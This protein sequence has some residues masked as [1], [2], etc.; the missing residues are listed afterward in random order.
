MLQR[1]RGKVTVSPFPLS[2]VCSFILSDV[3]TVEVV[4]YSTLVGIVTR[5]PHFLTLFG[6]RK[7]T[8]A[9]QEK[10]FEITKSFQKRFM[11]Q[12]DPPNSWGIVKLVF[13]RKP[14]AEPQKVFLR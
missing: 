10:I 9:H 7:E 3:G 5:F 12:G 14:D 13:F 8:F 1:V 6:L 11:G 2:A 4:V